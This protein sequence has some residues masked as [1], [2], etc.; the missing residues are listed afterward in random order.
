MNVGNNNIPTGNGLPKRGNSLPT[1]KAHFGRGGGLGGKPRHPSWIQ[2]EIDEIR[3]KEKV[4]LVS[5]SES[6][7]DV[8][9]EFKDGVL[10]AGATS[11][12]AK[13]L[14][15]TLVDEKGE[16]IA[17]IERVYFGFG[18]QQSVFTLSPAFQSYVDQHSAA[19]NV[20]TARALNSEF[21]MEEAADFVTD[22]PDK[23]RLNAFNALLTDESKGKE[24]KKTSKRQNPSKNQGGG[25]KKRNS[26]GRF[27][28]RKE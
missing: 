1:G 4:A 22:L 7:T 11:T 27:A 12:P 16:K 28:K 9:V 6:D 15:D 21:D 24:V 8:E 3:A 20:L 14:G 18:G 13:Q 19:T 26:N 5:G 25:G 23:D 17:S 10:H 2:S